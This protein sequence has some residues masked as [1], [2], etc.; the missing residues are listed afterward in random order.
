MLLRMLTCLAVEQHTIKELADDV[1][2]DEQRDIADDELD[3]DDIPEL[4]D[5]MYDPP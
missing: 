2:A 5:G 4:D 3:D 1:A